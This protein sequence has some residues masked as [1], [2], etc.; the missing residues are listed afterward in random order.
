[1]PCLTCLTL[2][3]RS[4]QPHR[5]H[6]FWS[7]VYRFP[8]SLGSILDISLIQL[9]LSDQ[10]SA[11]REWAKS[12]AHSSSTHWHSLVWY[13][14]PCFEFLPNLSCLTCF[15]MQQDKTLIRHAPP[16]FVSSL[17][18][19]SLPLLRRVWGAALLVERVSLHKRLGKPQL[20]R[21]KNTWRPR[22]PSRR[23]LLPY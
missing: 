2:L 12:F 9:R 7:F 5:F 22:L 15:S 4:F 16:C 18:F 11:E 19:H 10:P 1:M 8:A 3:W 6:L 21:T 14:S 23:P 20:A 13:D 17:T